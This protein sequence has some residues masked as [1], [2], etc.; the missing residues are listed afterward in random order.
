MRLSSD[1]VEKR[2]AFISGYFPYASLK[3]DVVRKMLVE[4]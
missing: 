3:T 1:V 4:G 2:A